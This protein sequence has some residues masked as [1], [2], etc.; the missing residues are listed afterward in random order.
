MPKDF[1]KDS[2]QGPAKAIQ[3]RYELM[4]K[5]K[6]LES[7]VQEYKRE[8]QMLKNRAMLLDTS[9]DTADKSN[10]MKRDE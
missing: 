5:I 1:L 6:D 10:Q 3:V 8:L 7:L 4:R 2:D 9:F